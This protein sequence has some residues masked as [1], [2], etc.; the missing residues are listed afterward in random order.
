MDPESKRLQHEMQRPPYVILVTMSAIGPLALNMFV[1][2]MPGL[3]NTFGATS[4]TVQLTLS[5]YLVATALCQLFYGPLSDRYGRRPLV[6]A[7]LA[8]FVVASIACAMATS[9]E[10]LIVARAFQAIGGAA[11]MILARAIVR[12]LF[13]QERAASVLGYVTMAWVLAPMFAPSIGGL[14]DQWYSF[15]AS[16]IL[17]SVLG[18]IALAAAWI[19]LPETNLTL[20]PR[21]SVFRVRL[22]GQFLR[23]GAFI[24]YVATVSFASAVFFCYLSM[25]PFI[26]VTVR[27]HTPFEYGLWFIC[28][29]FGYMAGNFTSGR[30]SERFGTDR[31]IYAGNMFTLIGAL[32]LLGFAIGDFHPSGL[33]FH[34]HGPLQFWQRA[35]HPQRDYRRDFC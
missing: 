7:G 35:G 8:L 3:Q 22:Y 6:L 28:S 31:M 19:T 25:A 2:S 12:D 18:V 27:H 32:I 15:R 33:Y 4:G 20:Q 11:G 17:L 5:V 29:S 21:A 34:T 30:Y 16:F 24:R 14:L 1:P 9:I 23:S 10:M 13:S 26:M